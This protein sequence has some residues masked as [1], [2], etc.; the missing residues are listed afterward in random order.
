MK[1]RKV[2]AVRD[3]SLRFGDVEKVLGFFCTAL[4]DRELKIRSTL[5]A[6][7]ALVRRNHHLPLTDGKTVYLPPEVEGDSVGSFGYYVVLAAHQTG[8]V[9]FG[10]FD[11]D[12]DCFLAEHNLTLS[13]P[14]E[15]SD[16]RLVSHFELFFRLFK[17]RQLAQDIFFAVEDGRIDYHL[18]RRYAGLALKLMRVSLDSLGERPSPS[19]LP[20]IEAIVECLVRLSLGEEPSSHLPEPLQPLWKKTAAIYARVLRANSTVLDSASAVWEIYR[21][22]LQFQQQA[23][24]SFVASEQTLSDA[25]ENEDAGIAPYHPSRPVDFRGQTDP[26]RVQINAALELLREA[27]EPD[28]AGAQ[29]SAEALKELLQKG[30]KIKITGVITDEIE[31]SAGLFVTDLNGVLQEKLRELTVEEKK[32]LSRLL[33]QAQNQSKADTGSI[34]YYDEWDYLAGDYRRRWCRLQEVPVGPASSDIVAGIR[35]EHRIL[36]GNVRRHY[37]RIRPEMLRKVK[38]L[39]DGEELE[40]DH[41]IESLVDRRA[42]LTPTGRIYQNRERK[43]RDIATCFLLDLSAST[44][45]WVM[46]QPGQQSPHKQ[47][48][49]RPNLFSFFGRDTSTELNEEFSPPHGA[50]R[51]IDI[52]RE[53]LVIIAEA[54]E[55]LGDEYAIYG[56]SGYGREN[57]EFLRIKD[58]SEPYSE[59]VRRK[60]GAIEPRKSTRMGPAIRHTVSKLS[61]SGKRMKVLILLSDGYP[62]DFDYGPDRSSREYGLHDTMMALKEARDRNIHTFC[63]TVD[64][65]GNDYLHDMCGGRDYFVV[66]KPGALPRILPFI[67]RKLTV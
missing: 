7:A 24:I 57:I 66:K 47:P 31:E 37:Q 40:L 33:N 19:L 32:K 29:L 64:Q 63:I 11:L 14:K 35:R 22:L 18:C 60:V 1:T 42:G 55:G 6:P 20:P 49:A 67:Y 16:P 9:E 26:A 62:Q 59:R 53:A 4:A 21:E 38:R 46:E 39:P 44:D 54:L 58:F 13:V 27:A 43:L 34:Y 23:S 12:I 30:M 2:P 48:T 61:G 45:E 3:C 8:Y 65:A 25:G 15:D 51:V 41:V 10:S 5:D 56:F 28:G 17:N 36:I 52:E 50:K